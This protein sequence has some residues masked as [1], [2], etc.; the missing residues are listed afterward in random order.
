MVEFFNE[1]QAES[2]PSKPGRYRFR[3]LKNTILKLTF[4]VVKEYFAVIYLD[5][6][7]TTQPCPEAVEAVKK[8]M[9]DCWGNPSAS[10]SC[11]RE[12]RMALETARFQVASALGANPMEIIF[13]SGG[14]EADNHAIL[15][16][17]RRQK[18]YGS[19]I[20]SSLTE[21]D[22]VLEPLKQL[23]SDG[24]D[25]T[26]LSPDENGRISVASVENALR[27]DTS[28]IS[29]MLVNNET[30]AINPIPEISRLI[31]GRNILLH[32]DCVQAMR[33]VPF[34]VRSLGADLISVSS[35]K[36]NGPK[37][38]GALWVKNSAR[39]TPFIFG[40]GQEGGLRSGTEAVPAI[41]GFGAAAA[42]PGAGVNPR[43][44][45]LIRE[46]FPD[47]VVISGSEGFSS[48]IF[49]FSLPGCKAEVLTNW[50]DSIGIFVSRGS[51]C[52]KGRRS[53]V[54]AAMGLPADVID[55]AIRVS[56]SPENTEADVLTFCSELRAAK[57][58]FF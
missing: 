8:A 20:I 1:V 16:G 47:A 48:H 49:M 52:A 10:Y 2:C 43:L 38:A 42:R 17:A 7:A 41:A 23:S 6:A 15:C 5:N 44:R 46:S 33:N 27:D 40:G 56:F 19:H 35:H 14:T 24:F 13:T 22:A 3:L 4:Q 9:T 26:L 37:G 32:C 30:G 25:V 54:L 36:I 12:A 45:E 18:R 11:G 50:L 34:T 28:F 31:R 21:H 29:L 55:G 57:E 51:A 39:L 58:R 53:H